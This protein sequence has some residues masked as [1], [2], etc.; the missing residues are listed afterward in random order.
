M[1]PDQTGL[2]SMAVEHSEVFAAVA[3][4][5]RERLVRCLDL[6]P[7]SAEGAASAWA[8]ARGETG[9]KVRQGASG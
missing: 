6:V 9:A 3:V 2:V 8:Y 7:T 1:R 4:E 5:Q